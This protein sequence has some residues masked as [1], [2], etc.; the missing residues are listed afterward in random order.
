LESVAEA[1]R[2]AMRVQLFVYLSSVSAYGTNHAPGI[3]EDAP[4]SGHTLP[5][6]IDKRETDLLCQQVFPRLGGAALCIF[7]PHIYAGAGIQNWLIDG[8]C[9]RASGKGWLA[10]VAQRRGW[11][12]AVLLPGSADA[13]HAIQLVHADDVARTLA[14]TVA[15]FREGALEILNLA[16]EGTLTL[17]E[18]AEMARTPIL[19][20]GGERTVRFLL[21]LSYACG[22]SAVPVEALPYYLAPPTMDTTRLRSTLGKDFEVVMRYTTRAALE[23]TLKA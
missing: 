15:H 19:R 7:R 14:W 20:P 6:A 8:V 17:E 21:R 22:L 23:D 12:V 1:N 3:R 4:L 9:G 2:S 11:H 13:K 5:Y 16:A 10:R 18:C